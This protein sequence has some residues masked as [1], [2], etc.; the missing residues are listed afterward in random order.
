MEYE[1]ILNNETV[2]FDCEVSKEEVLAKVGEKEYR[3][4]F[5]SIDGNTLS[6]KNTGEH[7]RVYYAKGKDGLHVFIDGEKF[8][9]Q[10]ASTAADFSGAGAAGAVGGGLV[11]SPMPGTIIKF[12]VEEGDE[13]KV[14]QGLVIVEAMKMEN[15]IRSNIDG[16]VKKINFK[17]GDA[18]DIGEPIMDLE[19]N[20][21][22]KG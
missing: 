3:F 6:L 10:E 20:K 18:V 17:P 14:D 21:S 13:V 4:D 16:V 19:E 7:R 15:E 5:S 2:V 11:A 1:Y 12:L 22:K 8:F 9:L